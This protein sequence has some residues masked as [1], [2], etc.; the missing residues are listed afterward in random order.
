MRL[1]TYQETPIS[2]ILAFIDTVSLS[3]AA[4]AG[5]LAVVNPCGFPL[6][7]AF[8]SFYLG[9]D[10]DGLP[11]AP[12]R[13][14]Q[15]LKVGGLVAVGFLATFTVVGLPISLGVGAIADA[16]P[17]VGLA[18]GVVL[19]L[20]GVVVIAGRPIRVN[21]LPRARVRRE[22]RVGAMVL[23]GIGYGAASLGCT[24]PIF[25]ALVGASLGADRIPAFLAYGAGM[26]VVLMAL[27]VAV[28][29]AR[30]GIARWLR[31]LLP[32]VGRLGGA[33]LVVSGAYLA[34]YWARVRF[35]NSVTLADDPIVGVATRYSADLQ[36]FAERHGRPLIAAAVVVV[37]LALASGLRGRARRGTGIATELVR[38]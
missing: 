27:A 19:A 9:A 36:D 23:F 20:S 6:L 2:A 13:V 25:L 7:P 31:P 17:W 4:T 16:V 10:E 14:L 30:D 35:G 24:L 15:G 8:L 34:Y 22:R 29:C 33:L 1:L 28:A 18:T 26:S 21:F 11:P 5:G 32:H 38:R 12:T 37:A 3:I